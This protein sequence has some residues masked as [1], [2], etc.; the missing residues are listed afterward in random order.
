[1]SD[2]LYSVSNAEELTEILTTKS[3][4]LNTVV[5]DLA[6]NIIELD[7]G[8][9]ISEGNFVIQNGSII[10]EPSGCFNVAGAGTSLTF[11]DS[12]NIISKGILSYIH[13]RGKLYISTE[14]CVEVN[15]SEGGIVV[16][17]SGVAKENSN[18][19]LIKGTVKGDDT[20]I[21]VLKGGS[22]FVGADSKLI[23]QPTAIHA[24]G[25]RTRLEICKDSIS[26]NIETSEEVAVE[27]LELVADAAEIETTVDEVEAAVKTEVVAEDAE[28]TKSVVIEPQVEEVVEEIKKPAELKEESLTPKSEPAKGAAIIANSPAVLF[29]PTFVFGAPTTKS[30]I[31]TIHGAITIIDE[32]GD[33]Y[34][35]S[36][37]M[38]GSFKRRNFGYIKKSSVN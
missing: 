2:T 13:R 28:E 1:M 4:G 27:Y 35:I 30:Y 36:F 26:G 12:L 16:E 32:I 33:F 7:T 14:G 10:A 11:G 20:T 5:V 9:D 3:E 24:E 34:K 31:C 6:G 37:M 18:V 22:V 17:G 15:D 38:P 8:I 19:S 29:K 21:T 25:S 23:G